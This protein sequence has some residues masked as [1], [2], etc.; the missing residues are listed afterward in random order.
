MDIND[1]FTK[2]SFLKSIWIIHWSPAVL[3]LYEQHLH[4]HLM[5]VVLKKITFQTQVWDNKLAGRHPIK[6]KQTSSWWKLWLFYEVLGHHK[7]SSESSVHQKLPRWKISIKTY[8]EYYDKK[9]GPNL[10]KP[11]L[12]SKESIS[13]CKIASVLVLSKFPDSI[14]AVICCRPWKEN[15]KKMKIS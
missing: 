7:E 6:T 15:M 12:L 1:K 4:Q 10:D 11:F 8:L 2:K 3:F 14:A 9:V 5:E 13:F